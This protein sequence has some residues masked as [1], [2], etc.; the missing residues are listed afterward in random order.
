MKW[1]DSYFTFCVTLA[2]AELKHLFH[3]TE[4]QHPIGV[5]SVD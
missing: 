4:P 1:F 2:F 3:W 5:Q